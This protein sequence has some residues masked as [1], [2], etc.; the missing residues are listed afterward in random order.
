MD[1]TNKSELRIMSH[2]IWCG[3]VANRDLH[4]RDIYLRYLPDVL[5]LQ[6]MTPNLYES[7]LLSLIDGEYELLLHDEAPDSIDNTP[8]LLRRGVFN[9]V[10]H[11]WHLYRGLNNHNSKSLA[12]AVLERKSDK[13]RFGAVSTHF[14]WRNGP[15]SDIARA[16]DVYQMMA[17]VNYM[18]VK[19]NIPVVAMGDWNCVINSMPYNAAVA[20]GGLDVRI[21]AT[22][23][24]DLGNTHHPYAVFNE[25]SGEYEN[26]P[27]PAGSRLNAIDHMF[28][29]GNR[30]F[31]IR[32]FHV[33]TEQ[34][35]L[36]VSDHC[37]I[38]MDCNLRDLP[39]APTAPKTQFIP[40][41]KA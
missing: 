3:K 19:Y 24:S 11:G 28:V 39:V 20:A 9:V 14:W 16:D 6:E 41:P 5:G 33:V 34:D 32:E 4:M 25:E 18:R 40:E 8:L 37:P 29:Y 26:G 36:D 21:C 30:G 13:R 15:E 35:A 10:E 12:W 27:K 38:Y 7:R 23:F 22:D 2:N 17:Y 1:Y 31:D